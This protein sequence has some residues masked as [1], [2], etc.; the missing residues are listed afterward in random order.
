M[1][2]IKELLSNAAKIIELQLKRISTELEEY[3]KG[4]KDRE[5][6]K[7]YVQGVRDTKET[8]E[9]PKQKR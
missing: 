1:K 7:G 3:N 2:R 9:K 4:F 5:Y 6:W 8:L